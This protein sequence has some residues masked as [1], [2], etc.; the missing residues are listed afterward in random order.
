MADILEQPQVVYLSLKSPQEPLAAASI[1]RLFL[2]SLFSCA[3]H[4]PSWDNRVYLFID[5]FQRIIADS[6]ELVFEQ[7]RGLGVTLIPVHQTVGQ[8]LRQG[9][10]F[11]DTLDANAA[12][13]HI[14]RASDPKSIKRIEEASGLQLYHSLSWAQFLEELKDSPVDPSAAIEGMMQVSSSIGPDLDKNTIMKVSADPLAS[15]VRFTT[16]GGYTQYGGKTTI[17]QSLFP[18]E[19]HEYNRRVRANWP[20]LPDEPIV[21][22]PNIAPEPPARPTPPTDWDKRLRDDS[23]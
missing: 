20:T 19:L 22:P 15:F 8:L 9:T 11:A 10:A 17:I 21:P 5:E 4:N 6:V 14:L 12:V 18:V 7:I 23:L 3:G 13:K 2:A 16:Q 1:A